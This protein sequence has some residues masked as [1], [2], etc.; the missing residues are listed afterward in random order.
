MASALTAAVIVVNGREFV[1]APKLV[2]K[3]KMDWIYR[4]PSFCSLFPLHFPP[5]VFILST[6]SLNFF[7]RASIPVSCS[8]RWSL[9]YQPVLPY[10]YTSV[11]VCTTGFHLNHGWPMGVQFPYLFSCTSSELHMGC[12]RSPA[13]KCV[14][15]IASYFKGCCVVTFWKSI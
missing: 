14:V 2:Q 1:D 8:Y 15:D 4:C 3:E 9:Y 12:T 13:C 7:S 6:L 5:K 10:N 11:T